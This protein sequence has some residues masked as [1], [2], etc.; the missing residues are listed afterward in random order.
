MELPEELPDEEPPEEPSEDEPP[1][2]PPEEFP[3]EE[4]PEEPPD[5]ELPEE[6][7]DEESPEEL[8]DEEP[9]EEPPEGLP[10]EEPPDEEPPDEEPPEEPPEEELPD[11]EPPEE[12]S[13]EE[14]EPEPD[15]SG[16]FT[17]GALAPRIP[18]MFP[19]APPV[20]PSVAPPEA[21]IRTSEAL[22]FPSSPVTAASP[23]VVA[24][25]SAA[26]RAA[27]RMA[28]SAIWPPTLSE[29]P[30]VAPLGIASL[31]APTTP[32]TA[33]PIAASEVLLRSHDFRS[34]L[35]IWIPWIPASSATPVA[36]L[37]RTSLRTR[38]STSCA[39]FLNPCCISFCSS[40]RKI[41]CTV[42]R[43]A[44]CAGTMPAVDPPKVTTAAAIMAAMEIASMISEA[45]IM[46]FVYSTSSAVASAESP[47]AWQA[48]ASDLKY[49]SSP[50]TN[51]F[52]ASANLSAPSPVHALSTSSA[53]LVPMSAAGL[54]AFAAVCQASRRF[55]SLSSSPSGQLSPTTMGN[56]HLTSSGISIP[57]GQTPPPSFSTPRT[58][59]SAPSMLCTAVSTLVRSARIPS[60][61]DVNAFTAPSAPGT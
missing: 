45:M 18:S 3:D 9:P 24:T 31:A 49:A 28:P 55:R 47:S 53:P 10:D 52:Q 43:V 59:S 1:E 7:P 37:I 32:S 14:D 17:S 8:P 23:T 57:T 26:P 51:F 16:V 22:R 30:R 11:D 50:S 60:T 58:V 2:E 44:I 19:F 29:T 27:P 48:S 33:P 5:V 21:P 46:Y 25:P 15:V 39:I 20:A 6:L 35:A 54:I 4:P 12:P 41:I 38:F 40:C 36:T 34:P 42:I 13:E 61:M 56:S